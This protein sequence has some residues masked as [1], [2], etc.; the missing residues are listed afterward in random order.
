MQNFTTFKKIAKKGNLIALKE[1]IPADLETPV[2][3]FLKV[4][5]DEKNAFLLESA[6]YAESIGR[7]SV[8]GIHPQKVCSQSGPAV[9]I[10]DA[11]GKKENLKRS[12]LIDVLQAEMKNQKLANPEEVEGFCGGLVG[13]SKSSKW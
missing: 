3:T 10:L 5:N 4:A 7:Y 6:E 8:I 1:I 9:G 2:S 12:K 13:P 11:N